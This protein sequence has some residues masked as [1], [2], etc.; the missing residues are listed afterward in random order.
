MS[1]SCK[2]NGYKKVGF[3][4]FNNFIQKLYAK[5]EASTHP[6][7]MFI[8]VK[9]DKS[10]MSFYQNQGEDL[11]AFIDHSGFYIAE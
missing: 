4:A 3:R 9:V 8:V 6:L 7:G 5:E 2:I 10:S 1:A 11:L